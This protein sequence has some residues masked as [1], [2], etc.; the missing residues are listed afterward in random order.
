MFSSLSP[1]W[2]RSLITGTLSRVLDVDKN[3]RFCNPDDTWTL[4]HE[5]CRGE[6]RKLSFL[7]D[8]LKSPLVLSAVSHVIYDKVDFI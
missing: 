3:H 5:F 8:Y 1:E 4:V 6:P 2:Q 7:L